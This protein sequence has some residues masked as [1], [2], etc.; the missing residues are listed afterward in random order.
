M[1]AMPTSIA[2]IGASG[3]VGSTLAAQVLRSQILEPGDRLQLV[4]HGSHT[5]EG[6]LLSTRIDLLDAFDDERVEIEVVPKILDVDADI[7]VVAAGVSVSLKCP[8]RRDVGVV[9][10]GIFEYIAEQCAI[11]VPEALFIVV[12]NPVELAVHIL[13]S[14]LDRR[15]VIGMGAEQ[16]SLRFARAIAKD[17]GISRRDVRAS[18]LGEH[19]QAMVPLWSTVEILASSQRLLDSLNRLKEQSIK[20]PLRERVSALHDKA[21]QLLMAGQVAEAYEAARDALPDA[22]IFVEPFITVRSMHSTPNATSNATLQCIAAALASDRRRVHGQVRLE[23]DVLDLH[24]TCGLPITLGR[25]GWRP[26]PL[27]WLSVC[28][29]ELLAGSIASI[30]DF[31][32]NVFSQP[33]VAETRE[34]EVA[35]GTGG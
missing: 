11:R 12:S 22:R 20:V 21:N 18:V 27:D 4:G 13:S 26:E 25:D 33:L 23:G 2:I 31:I 7:V 34:E 6:K 32:A 29:K 3:S 16:D 14:R 5:S 35:Y 30:N 9:N 24:G 28:E 19:G 1:L 8:T 10:R 17:L 15:R